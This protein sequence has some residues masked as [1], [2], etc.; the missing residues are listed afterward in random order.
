MLATVKKSDVAS[1]NAVVRPGQAK[2]EWYLAAWN[3]GFY[4]LQCWF[5]NVDS[6]SPPSRKLLA[7]IR[8]SHK[9]MRSVRP[10]IQCKSPVPRSSCWGISIND[11]RRRQN[12]TNGKWATAAKSEQERVHREETKMNKKRPN[13]T[14]M[15][16][17]G[18]LR[19]F[20][21]SLFLLLVWWQIIWRL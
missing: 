8:C 1:T 10:T 20:S 14:V 15:S 7:H 16:F 11:V 2:H 18:W 4:N 13:L 3:L 5:H 12:E 17:Q 19:E 6:T 21:L 9:M